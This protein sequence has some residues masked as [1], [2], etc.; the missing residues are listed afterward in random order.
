MLRH[1]CGRPQA[2]GLFNALPLAATQPALL[3]KNRTLHRCFH[4]EWSKGL[5]LSP[6]RECFMPDSAHS[7]E[8]TARSS[9]QNARSQHTL[10][11]LPCTLHDRSHFP[12]TPCR[13]SPTSSPTPYP[14]PPPPSPSKTPNSPTSWSPTLATSARWKSSMHT[15]LPRS[16]EKPK[17]NESSSLGGQ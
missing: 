7:H 16:S 4:A 12:P 17:L 5:G 13:P 6:G 14:S 8:R 10:S 2:A 9:A 1:G 15:R 11:P 3:G